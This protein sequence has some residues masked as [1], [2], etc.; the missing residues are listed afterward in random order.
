MGTQLSQIVG[1]NLPA[2]EAQACA[3]ERILELLS[4]T[5]DYL[6]DSINWR[7]AKAWKADREKDAKFWQKQQAAARAEIEAAGPTRPEEVRA[8]Y[9]SRWSAAEPDDSV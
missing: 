1:D 3:E 6:E 5:A 7:Q 9:D 4:E 2:C 8:A